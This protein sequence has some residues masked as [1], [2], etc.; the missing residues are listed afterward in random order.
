MDSIRTEESAAFSK[1]KTDLESGIAG[2]QKALEVLRE[3]YGSSFVQQPAMPAGH[4]AS[5]D[6]GGAIISMLEQCESDFTQ[7][8]SKESMEKEAQT[9]YDTTT[10][11]NKMTKTMKDQDVK[12][13]TA[14]AK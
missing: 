9:V 2:V 14:E 13:L 11:K 7:T 6:A 5:S 3:Y 10:Q 1:A 8:L 12:Y 4:S